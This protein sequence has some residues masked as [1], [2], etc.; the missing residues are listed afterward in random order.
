M[1]SIQVELLTGKYVATRF[2]DRARAEWPPHPARLFSAAVAAWADADEPDDRER[3]ALRWWEEQGD[4]T[5]SCSWGT[6]CSERAGVTHYVPG[7]DAQVVGRDLSSTYRKLREAIDAASVV[8]AGD[9]TAL[10]AAERAAAK[11]RSKAADDSAKAAVGRAPEGARRILP[12]ERDR[13]ARIYP[14]TIP[15]DDRVVYRWPTADADSA[16]VPVLD[17]LVAR[18]GRLGH[19]SSFVAVSVVDID[20]DDT[21]VPHETGGVALRV[22]SPGQ[23]DALE[24]AFRVHGSTE[25]RILPSRIMNYRE[26]D[27][28]AVTPIASVFGQ[29]WLVLELA[30]RARFTLRDSL[31][32]ARAVRGALLHHSD[33]D[34]AP[35][36]LS[37]HQPGPSLPTPA[38]SR[39]HVAIVPLPFAGHQH[40]DG[41]VRAI[42]LVVPRAVDASDRD[43]VERA[44][45][46]WMGAGGGIQLGARGTIQTSPADLIDAAASAQ[47][48][49][50]CQAARRWV[51]VTPIAL[52]RNPGNLRHRD[53]ARRDEAERAAED[54]VATAC[55]HVGLPSPISVTIHTDPLVRGSASIR[56][57]P[58]Y[59]VQRGRVQRVLVHAE[60]EFLEPVVGP[61]LVGAGR[62]VGYGLCLPADR[63]GEASRG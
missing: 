1:L 6:D 44:V 22:A 42:A 19:S 60:I 38:T 5:V 23:L 2:N 26:S 4:P 20:A 46:A 16:H 45:G 11:A 49:R 53:P 17:G 25:P 47:P 54:I 31:A 52:D 13:Q 40:A 58:T 57:F 51:S 43:H 12:D 28:R 27:T 3:A 30:G 50:W 15:A 59:A 18:I 56:S 36:I 8:D 35:E 62:Y 63:A 55:E 10:A 41:L 7:N 37:G 24:A 39:A 14:T 61:V 29:D 9:Q 32:L 33:L 21:L 34:P 48:S